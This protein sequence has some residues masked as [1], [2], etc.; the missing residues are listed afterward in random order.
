LVETGA[1]GK[2]MTVIGQPYR[3]RRSWKDNPR[4]KAIAATLSVG[5]ILILVFAILSM[6]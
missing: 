2:E 5:W 1:E 6:L 4:A 3:R